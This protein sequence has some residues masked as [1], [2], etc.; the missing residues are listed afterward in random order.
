MA[1]T[2][3]FAVRRILQGHLT[4]G[5]FNAFKAYQSA[6]ASAFE[7]LLHETNRL[8]QSA[9]KAEAFFEIIDRKPSILS[10]PDGS[11]ADAEFSAY[12]D[13][14][15][16][17]DLL[18]QN[19]IL[20]GYGR[21]RAVAAA[22]AGV[23]NGASGNAVAGGD[24]AAAVP[25]AGDADRK[26]PASLG[27][28]AGMRSVSRASSDGGSTEAVSTGTDDATGASA[29]MSTETSATVATIAATS[30][31]TARVATLLS[32]V[33]SYPEPVEP[34]GA[35]S[36]TAAASPVAS[37]AATAAPPPP[38]SPPLTSPAS[39]LRRP[40]AWRIRGDVSF[41][42]VCFKYP[43]TLGN[44]DAEGDALADMS[45]HIPAGTTAAFVGSS[46]SG[47]STIFRLLVRFYDCKD[48]RVLIDGK[49]IRELDA[50]E[51][52]RQIGFIEQE[53]VMLNRSI[54]EN[55]AYGFDPRSDDYP[56]QDQ[57]V[58]AAKHAFIHDAIMSFPDGYKTIVGE[59]G[60]RLSTGE[61]QRISIARAFIRDPSILLC[62]E[63]TASLD[64][65]A[66]VLVTAGIQALM[67]GRTVIMIAHRLRT[68]QDADQLFV[69]SHG[70]IVE[71]GRH[72]QLLAQNGRYMELV[73]KQMIRV[74]GTDDA[75]AGEVAGAAGAAARAAAVYDASGS[76]ANLTP[77]AAG[78][79]AVAGAGV[80]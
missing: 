19:D 61:K 53:P 69:L 1:G 47:K 50:R 16:L 78:P 54:A 74:P 75:G 32:S 17:T 31:C 10:L 44:T 64:A 40:R 6:A 72:A 49:D 38:I 80:E 24:A 12:N 51:L 13:D 33:P 67:R 60:L 8:R 66:E 37:S 7:G 26:L 57:I 18:H 58:Q 76:A 77:A 68:V 63:T 22:M 34:T 59:R 48:G 71:R 46:G 52:R 65:E 55:I 9:R 30:Q 21:T 62:D 3:G 15:S 27:R 20:T 70:K 79:V 73:T 45:F 41:D 35:A 25:S 56:T 14:Q 43:R 2:L 11:V 23:T 42:H 28:G 5:T 36:A 39:M 4:V 29:V